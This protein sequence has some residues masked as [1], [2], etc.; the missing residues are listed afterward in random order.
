MA[1]SAIISYMCF[2]L[3]HRH[4]HYTSL[5][6]TISIWQRIKVLPQMVMVQ[7]ILILV[8]DCLALK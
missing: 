7:T 3:M 2:Y 6:Q 1:E 5:D 4:R 8:T